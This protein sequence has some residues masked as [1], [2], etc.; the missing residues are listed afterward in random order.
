MNDHRYLENQSLIGT[1]LE[2][3]CRI[4][5]SIFYFKTDI[6]ISDEEIISLQKK[7]DE[8]IDVLIPFVIEVSKKVFKKDVFLVV[9]LHGLGTFHWLYKLYLLEDK[10]YIFCA[11]IRNF[12]YLGFRFII[13]NW[14]MVELKR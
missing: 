9:P 14:V 3:F 12:P 8:E 1:E 10:H 13:D 2:N 4:R 7:K 6:P 5:S 11:V